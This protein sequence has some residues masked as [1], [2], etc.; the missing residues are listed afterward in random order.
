MILTI[1]IPVYNG[2]KYI[3]E[4]I[5]KI[6]MADFDW[7]NVEVLVSDNNSTD[8]SCTVVEKYSK[9]KLYK[10]ASN[11][12]YDGNINRIFNYA[13]GRYVWTIGADDILT[14]SDVAEINKIVASDTTYSVIYVGEPLPGKTGVMAIAED[15]L[16]ASDF[17]SGFVSNNIINK[18]LWLNS[19]ASEFIGSGWIHYGMVLK[20]LKQA[21]SYI[22]SK[23]Y[24]TEI[25]ETKH[26]KSWIKGGQG[27]LVGLNLVE[28]FDRMEIWGYSTQMKRRCKLVIKGS[29]PKIIIF[30]KCIGLQINLGILKRFIRL[31]SEF[32]SFWLI[33]MPI[34]VT[35][36]FLF[37]ALFSFYK[38][39]KPDA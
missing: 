25:E 33:D 32:A 16:Y 37:T 15:F 4:T 20:V 29:Y 34:L 8:G 7:Q 17:R 21:P 6:L 19:E 38:K 5:T 35:P 10:H 28:I 18:Q 1:G 13:Q 9:V 36:G 31:Y 26:N 27:L 30:S 3:E 24:V 14:T 39:L 12:G 2:E 23:M 22:M 11:V